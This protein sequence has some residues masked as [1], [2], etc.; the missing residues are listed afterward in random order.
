MIVGIDGKIKA[1]EP[2][3][4]S[5]ITIEWSKEAIE[6]A[7]A[8]QGIVPLNEKSPL[9]SDMRAALDAAVMAQFGKFHENCMVYAHEIGEARGRNDALK[10]AEKVAES[11]IRNEPSLGDFGEGYDAAC[12][13]IA[14]RIRAMK[15]V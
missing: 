9:F 6:A 1:G 3:K 7:L 4:D 15:T 10:E 11:S 13:E 12:S 14:A 2:A 8:V 5:E